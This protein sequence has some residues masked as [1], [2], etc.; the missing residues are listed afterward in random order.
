MEARAMQFFHE[1]TQQALRFFNSAA[2]YFFT[3]IV[4]QYAGTESV[5]KHQMLAA[6]CAHEAETQ[7]AQSPGS[8]DTFA[9]EHCCSALKILTHS[10]PD[11]C[12]MLV[13][14]LLFIAIESLRNNA[15]HV[16]THL[17]SGLRI[18]REWKEDQQWYRKDSSTNAIVL[19]YIEPIF[20][21]L[22]QTAARAKASKITISHRWSHAEPKLPLA[23]TSVFEA[24]EVGGQLGQFLALQTS[25]NPDPTSEPSHLK[26]VE[27]F[28]SYGRTLRKL[29]TSTRQWS[30]KELIQLEFLEFNCIKILMALDCQ[31][32]T[33][34]MRWDT[35]IN[36]MRDDVAMGE[37]VVN[38][39]VVYQSDR[40]HPLQIDVEVNP[41]VFSLT[42]HTIL[43]CRDPSLRQRCVQI[44]RQH[45][46]QCGHDDECIGAVL[47]ETMIRLEEQGL[48][49][50][51]SCHNIPESNRIRALAADITVPGQ[52][53][54]TFARS[55]YTVAESVTV[56]CKSATTPPAKPF[57]LWPIGAT[58][59]IAGYQGL[60]RSRARFCLC[61][62]FG[63]TWTQKNEKR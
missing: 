42:W 57:R 47:T 38:N 48:T 28:Q 6:A 3:F 14:C 58:L 2:D 34:E 25:Q 11:L 16:Y 29:K 61:K 45:H 12:L 30:G 1:N 8:L 37:R 40:H 43:G 49:H 24:R 26:V 62:S 19:N 23:F 55:P 9:T 4:P 35:Y 54:L 39:P 17:Q 22:E 44:M 36:N 53:T 51:H 63:A 5:I 27:L 33:H 52:L 15:E 10:K 60:V 21:Q 56:V 7:M 50:I 41:G 46:Q 20:G 59:G 18:L 13:S 31:Q 32:M